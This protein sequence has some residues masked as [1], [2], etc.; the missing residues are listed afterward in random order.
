MGRKHYFESPAI[1]ASGVLGFTG[2]GYKHYKIL[3]I[4]TFGLFNY[5]L[6]NCIVFQSKT[7]TAFANKGN[8]LL[9]QDGFSLKRM[10][11]SCVATNVW[12]GWMVNNFSLSGPGLEFFIKQG[13]WHEFTKEF[14][15][16]IMLIGKTAEGRKREAL[17]IVSLLQ[18]SIYKFK[19]YRNSK[20][21]LNWN[22]SCPNTGHD[23]Q[24]DFLGS[25]EEEY[26]ILSRLR[27][28]ILVKVGW[29]F[30]ISVAKRLQK[31]E[32]IYGFVSINTIPFNEL[33]LDTKEKYFKK[34]KNGEF[35]SPL[36]KYQDEF[37]VKGR[38]GVSGHPIRPYALAWIR[39]AR[40]A[41]IKKPIIGGGGIMNPYNVWQFKK[42]GATAIS[43]GSGI[44]LRFWNLPLIIWAARVF[45]KEH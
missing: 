15:L 31:F 35:I 5:I 18:W 33:P 36:D 34:D 21:F 12:R 29:Q 41:G 37:N 13:V 28:P 45:F 1:A 25:F 19:A 23:A 8:A 27:L 26:R 20:V 24:A 4:L 44:S 17:H 43:L 10:M 38:G 14:H 9:A 6:R 7:T 16:S 40:K 42:A 32:F 22:I 39:N 11:P 3:N 30:P 2:E